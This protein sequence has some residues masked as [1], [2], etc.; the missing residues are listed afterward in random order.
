MSATALRD[1]T[2]EERARETLRVRHQVRLVKPEEEGTPLFRLP[3]GVYGFTY[4]PASH[5]A[6]L[7]SKRPYLC[8]ELHRLTNEDSR[9]VGFATSAQA[10]ALE[11]GESM[12]LNVFPEPYGDATEP[13][14]VPLGRIGRA[15]PLA[16]SEGNK[17]TLWLRPAVEVAKA[18]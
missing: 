7:F 5:E 1:V 10:A 2:A 8:F 9:L 15:K 12:D 13:V 3:Q 18:S 11:K 6:G 14:V 16:R 4:S 17:L